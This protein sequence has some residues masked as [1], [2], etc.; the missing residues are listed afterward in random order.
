MHIAAHHDQQAL[1]DRLD[2]TKR[3]LETEKENYE[4]FKREASGKF[5]QDRTNLNVLKEE[6]SKHKTRLEENR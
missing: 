3:D 5:E 6:L 4:R 1:L 2:A